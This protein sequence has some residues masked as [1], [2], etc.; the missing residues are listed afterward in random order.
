MSVQIIS[1]DSQAY[2]AFNGGEI[3]ENK[4][5]GFPREGGPTKPY[6]SL[7][8]W[9]NAIAKVESTIGLHPHE[10]FEIMS[11]VLDGTIRHY[12]TQ[13]KDWK[14]LNIGDAQIIRAGNGISH[15][16][17]MNEGSR[18]FQIWVDPNLNKTMQQPA[19]YNDYAA[20]D[21]P[22]SIDGDLEILH[23][24]GDKGIMHLDTPQVNIQKWTLNGTHTIEDMTAIHSLYVLSGT[25]TINGQLASTD[26]FI[27]VQD[28]AAELSGQGELFVMSTA[29][30][31]EYE[32]YGQMMQRRM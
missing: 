20:A 5:I 6:S 18:M 17:H 11:F 26:D 16:E 27:I 24:A 1:K 7:F 13:L 31:L 23:Y 30:K 3:V 12:D 22:R 15:A 19:S 9:A 21:I 25:L 14:E 10:G 2:G 28:E 8:Y 4:P 32:T 29:K